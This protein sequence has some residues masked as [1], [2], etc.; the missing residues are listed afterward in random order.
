MEAWGDRLPVVIVP[1]K[2]PDVP[3][4]TFRNYGVSSVIWANHNMRASVQAMQNVTKGIYDTQS[5]MDCEQPGAIATVSEVFRLQRTG[6]LK[7][8]ENKYENPTEIA[9]RMAP[10]P[11][12]MSN[13]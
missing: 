5:L 6:E 3:V 8:A 1:T 2:Y 9:K 11:N 4:D 7:E 12:P 10:G 13:A